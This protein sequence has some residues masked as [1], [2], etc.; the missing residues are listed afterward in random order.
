[1]AT[2]LVLVDD[3]AFVLFIPAVIAGTIF[4]NLVYGDVLESS[5]GGEDMTVACLAYPRRTS[6]YDVG[7]DSRHVRYISM[8][9]V[10]E[11]FIR[12]IFL[13]TKIHTSVPKNYKEQIT[14]VR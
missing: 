6:D 4:D 10:K 3:P 7:L 1:M 2:N 14:L 12:Y 9:G 11:G 13:N 5:I 8:N